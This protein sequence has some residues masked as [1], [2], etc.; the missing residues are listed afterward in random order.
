MRLA[1]WR[2]PFIYRFCIVTTISN[3][4]SPFRG[5]LWTQRGAWLVLKQAQMLREGAPVALDGDVIID[6]SNVAFIQATDGAR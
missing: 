3:P 5:V 6:R 1:F 4:D 2:A